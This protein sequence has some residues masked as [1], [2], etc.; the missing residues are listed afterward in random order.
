M[1]AITKAS[2]NDPDSNLNILYCW[3]VLC[4]ISGILTALITN[5]EM[6]AFVF[7]LQKHPHSLVISIPL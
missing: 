5:Y 7:R 4:S 1:M 2:G 3:L 6:K